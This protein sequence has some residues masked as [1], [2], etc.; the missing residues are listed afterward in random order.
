VLRNPRKKAERD[1]EKS[2]NRIRTERVSVE[3]EERGAKT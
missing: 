1:K 3:R 2:E